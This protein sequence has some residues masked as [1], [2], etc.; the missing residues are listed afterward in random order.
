MKLFIPHI[1]DIFILFIFTIALVILTT[2]SN[3]KN[4]KPEIQ[5]FNGFSASANS[6]S[7]NDQSLKN[8]NL[9]KYFIRKFNWVDSDQKKI[10]TELKIKK[11]FL[12]KEIKK[13]GLLRGMKN[14][15]FLKSRGFKVINRQNQ[16]INGQIKE[17]IKYIVDYKTI[18]QRNKP[19]FTELTTQLINSMPTKNNDP[20]YSFL[21][22]IQY[23]PYSRTPLR[24]SDKFINKFF[25]PLVCL[26]EQYG[27]CDSKSLLLSEF[28]ANYP[29]SKEKLGMVL[30]KG[31]GIAHAILA[32][33]RKPL[34]GMF[35]ILIRGS[36]Y[37]IPLETTRPRWSPGFIN[38]RVS[39]AIK[40]GYIRFV[41]LN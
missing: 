16:M 41:P 28:L 36:G 33:K 10:Q 20:L 7:L 6:I 32:V 22:F 2:Y 13:F 17:N 35:S 8:N 1:R 37:Y 38:Y 11:S 26:Y 5:T 39:K 40:T 14:P 21:K 9:D 3:F 24:Y 27:D 23:I 18:F 4:N 25:I 15:F 29:N 30:I 31:R 34:M 12:K 19:Y